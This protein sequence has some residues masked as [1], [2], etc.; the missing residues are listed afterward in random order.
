MFTWCIVL[1][2]SSL[3]TTK[4]Q[5]L[6]KMTT[7][8]ILPSNTNPLFPPCTARLQCHIL[9]QIV[10]DIHTALSH[11]TSCTISFTTF[12]IFDLNTLVGNVRVASCRGT[13]PNNMS[14]ADMQTCLG[15]VGNVI[16]T[17]RQILSSGPCQ[18]T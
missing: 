13:P 17:C 4:Q 11:H 9:S 6:G 16:L 12:G 3:N 1:C 2:I 7:P 8:P 18:T 14:F 5:G 10:C 15:N